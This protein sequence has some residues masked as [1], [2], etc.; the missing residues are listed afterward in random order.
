MLARLLPLALLLPAAGQAHRGAQLQRLRLLA[1]GH[2]DGFLKTASASAAAAPARRT[3]A[4]RPRRRAQHQLASQPIQLRLVGSLTGLLHDRQRPRR[5][6]A[7]ASSDLSRHA[8][9]PWPAARD[10]TACSSP[11][12]SPRRPRCA[13][14]TCRRPSA[15]DPL[16]GEDPAV[17]DLAVGEQE[18]EPVLRCDPHQRI[19]RCLRG[20][21]FAPQHVNPGDEIERER[22]AVRA[23]DL[24][25]RS[26]SAFCTC[27]QRL[28]RVAQQPATHGRETMA[29]H[30]RDR[31]RRATP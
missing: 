12:P 24:L 18:L 23:P 26:V 2:L 10:A 13:D 14:C 28:I 5:A 29:G 22:L 27:A 7:S 3:L 15:S 11:R 19:D 25:W 8:R 9:T 21:L 20:L 4:A 31:R 16:R 1:A 6:A 17:Q 30:A